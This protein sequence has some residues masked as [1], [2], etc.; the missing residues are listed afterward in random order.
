M[1]KDG[2]AINRHMLESSVG[3][4]VMNRSTSTAPGAKIREIASRT[5][6]DSQM[7]RATE[8]LKAEFSGSEILDPFGSIEDR[9][10]V[11]S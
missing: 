7:Q 9:V 10:G 2:G 5:N 8:I 3:Q 11:A 6:P 1:G 4:Q